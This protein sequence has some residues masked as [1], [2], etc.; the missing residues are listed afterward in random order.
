M[1]II[2]IMFYM[3][4][5][6]SGEILPEVYYFGNPEGPLVTVLAGSH[7]NEPA[8]ATFLRDYIQHIVDVPTGLYFA[9]IP[10]VDERAFAARKRSV[11]ADINR[12]WFS[13]NKITDYL[14]P[15]I[16][17]SALVV[18]F[19]EGWG[20]GACENSLGQTLF[21]T[22]PKLHTLLDATVQKLNL[23]ARD[24]MT[25]K[26]VDKLPHIAGT[27]DTYC[28]SLGIPYILAELAG[29][30]DVVPMG[31]RLEETQIILAELLGLK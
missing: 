12:M 23:Q 16:D 1:L 20:F 25:W 3:I 17:R 19:H 28:T 21:T 14:R 11:G 22:D 18:D 15:I 7:G 26:R 27:L 6:G 5:K 29:Q 30:N 8:P 24:C 2:S 10:V 31:I 13:K 9:I 4:F